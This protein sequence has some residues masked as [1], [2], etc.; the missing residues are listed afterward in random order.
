MPSGG[1]PSHLMHILRYGNLN[2]NFTSRFLKLLELQLVLDIIQACGSIYTDE[3]KD[4]KLCIVKKLLTFMVKM[5]MNIVMEVVALL[6]YIVTTVSIAMNV[7]R[8]DKNYE[9]D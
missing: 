4:K 2:L 7:T 6:G 5:Y 3:K 8:K 1:L 9:A